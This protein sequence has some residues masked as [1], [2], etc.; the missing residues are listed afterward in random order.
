M[1]PK[2]KSWRVSSQRLSKQDAPTRVTRALFFSRSLGDEF[3]KYLLSRFSWIDFWI[4][5]VNLGADIVSRRL[6][7]VI[8]AERDII[9]TR[10][11]HTE[12]QQNSRRVNFLVV[13]SSFGAQDLESVSLLLDYSAVNK[14]KRKRCIRC[15]VKKAGMPHNIFT[16]LIC[17][18]VIE[19]T[20]R[21]RTMSTR[22]K[23]CL[24]TIAS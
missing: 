14:I 2:Q 3:F 24:R 19:R 21:R 12:T 8:C 17:P 10:W 6:W 15:D 5:Y 20:S 7:Y 9:S 18:P 1:W 23:L 4:V 11:R 13:I 22:N 16:Y